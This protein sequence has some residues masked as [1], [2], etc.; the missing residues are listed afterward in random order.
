MGCDIHSF[1]DKKRA[2]GSWDLVNWPEQEDG[3]S[4]PW[5]WRSYGI[6]GFLADVRNYSEVPPICQP[7]GMPDDASKG[8][9]DKWKYWA[10]DGHS[11]SWLTLKELM[12]FRYDAE[13]ED[14][15]YMK[16]F[17][18]NAWDGAATH[19]VGSGKKTTFREF[20]GEGFF[21]HLNVIRSLGE[22]EEIRVIFWFDN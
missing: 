22:P 7:R 21:D 10:G 19:E 8:V 6:F 5:D 17:A 4:G 14:R 16:Q 2:D 12:D 1:I 11:C 3:N 20:L 15:R 13:M 9:A 18:A